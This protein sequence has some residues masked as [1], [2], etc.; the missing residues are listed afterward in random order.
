M[1]KPHLESPEDVHLLDQRVI[2][3][4]QVVHGERAQSE[5][6]DDGPVVPIGNHRQDVPSVRFGGRDD[7]H[8][9]DVDLRPEKGA[10]QLP[11]SREETFQASFEVGTRTPRP[12]RGSARRGRGEHQRRFQVVANESDTLRRTPGGR[13]RRVPVLCV[14][15]LVALL[16]RRRPDDEDREQLL[17]ADGAT[18]PSLVSHPPHEP[19][20]LRRKGSSGGRR[21]LGTRR[22]RPRRAVLG[23]TQ[24][25]PRTA[26]DIP[27]SSCARVRRRQM[28]VKAHRTTG[29][30]TTEPAEQHEAGV[31]TVKTAVTVHHVG[32]WRTSFWGH[33]GSI[34]PREPGENDSA[35]VPKFEY[36]EITVC[37]NA[38]PATI[39]LRG[40]KTVA[41]NRSVRGLV[42]ASLLQ[43]TPRSTMNAQ[44]GGP[45]TAELSQMLQNLVI[46]SALVFD[47]R[48]Q[49]CRHRA[50]AH[51]LLVLVAGVCSL[52]AK[53]V[54]SWAN[55][56]IPQDRRARARH[57]RRW[58]RLTL[59][60]VPRGV[61]GR[62][63]GRLEGALVPGRG[64]LPHRTAPPT[65]PTPSLRPRSLPFV[66][67]AR[68]QS[69]KVAWDTTSM[70]CQVGRS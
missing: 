69:P 10:R 46:G 21:T 38:P 24:V 9:Q 64:R 47:S 60:D 45:S 7:A 37:G 63:G 49:S 53:S 3:W 26:R 4:S 30:Q 22:A 43:R 67:A 55:A 28:S 32:A 48:P 33:L 18:W 8:L 27:N 34:S 23:A 19:F 40:S 13:G 61:A 15:L 6:H 12:V 70:R 51:G 44:L 1:C 59:G 39:P 56:S 42:D 58:L 16:S 14:L 62:R 11:A 65:R 68:G 20:D 57:C 52:L 2:R 17:L 29:A 36:Q 31:V 35:C 25:V 50:R 66:D 41:Q 5:L 54:E